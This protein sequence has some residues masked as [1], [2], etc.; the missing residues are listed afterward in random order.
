MILRPYDWIPLIFATAVVAIV[1]VR[2]WLR[3]R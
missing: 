2:D 1:I 3:K